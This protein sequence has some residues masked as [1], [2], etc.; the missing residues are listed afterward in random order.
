[1]VLG[2]FN[3]V[4]GTNTLQ[5]D[6]VQGPGEAAFLMKKSDF[7][8]HSADS[9]TLSLLAHGYKEKR[10]IASNGHPWWHHSESYWQRVI[11]L[12]QAGSSVQSSQQL[13]HHFRVL[14]TLKLKLKTGA[15]EWNHHCSG[16]MS[17]K[18]KGVSRGKVLVNSLPTNWRAG[19]GSTGSAPS[20]VC[21]K[22][23]VARSFGAFWVLQVSSPTVLLCKTVCSA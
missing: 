21:S 2:D 23:P 17:S 22:V 9:I 11:F 10:S 18:P 14:V 8:C 5:G 6:T 13:R 7:F 4:T 20:G 1:M 12:W 16:K 3:A 19:M 15:S